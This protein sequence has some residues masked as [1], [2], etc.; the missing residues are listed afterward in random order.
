VLFEEYVPGRELTVAV[1]RH[2]PLPVLEIRPKE[3]YY[4]YTNKYTAG[5]TEYLCP[6]P[7]PLALS[8][9]LQTL[10]LRAHAIIGC[11]GYSRVDFRMDEHDALWCLEVNTLPGMTGT[12][13]VPKAA[14]AVGM[15]YP[16]LCEAIVQAALS[17]WEVDSVS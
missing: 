3:G 16:E 9:E 14:A 7:L 5:K 4:D 13:L 2:E 10:A 12:S 8:E 17:R 11:E 1:V 15:S 6:A